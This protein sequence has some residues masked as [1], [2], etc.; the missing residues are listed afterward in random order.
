MGFFLGT[1]LLGWYDGRHP[2]LSYFT[3]PYTRAHWARWLWAVP[4]RFLRKL[5]FALLTGAWSFS[6]ESASSALAV[7][8]FASL[9]FLLVL[10]LWLRPYSDPRDNT[11]EAVCLTLL[12]YGYFVSVLPRASDS[13]GASVSAFQV[14]LVAYGVQHRVRERMAARKRDAEIEG[15]A[16]AADE[17][18][19]MSATRPQAAGT[20]DSDRE[21][22][23]AQY[24]F[25][26]AASELALPLMP[27]DA[28]SRHAGDRANSTAS[29]AAGGAF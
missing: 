24:R 27:D 22:L 18:Q 7:V 23:R 26:S 12:M 17:V 8:V 28:L 4:H 10:H 25:H 15:T 29:S 19:M 2:L 5:W 3:R 6:D 16:G 9:I 1:W 20:S 11:L 13:M 21:R 14:L